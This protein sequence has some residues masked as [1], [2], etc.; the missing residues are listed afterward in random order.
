MPSACFDVMVIGSNSFCGAGFVDCMLTQGY[1]VLGVSRSHLGDPSFCR[2]A[3]NEKI[4]NFQFHQIDLNASGSI[5]YLGDLLKK[6]ASPVVVNFSAQGMVAQSWDSPVDWYLTNV[7]AQVR[8]FELLRNVRH[9]EQYIHFSTPEVYG[10]NLESIDEGRAHNPTTPY[11]ISRSC[12]DRHLIA[13]SE[14]WG[15][16]AVITRASNVYGAYQQLYRIVPRTVLACLGFEKL[17]LDGGGDSL[18]N[19]LHV[20]DCSNALRL[21]IESSAQKN[22]YHISGDRY[23]SISDLVRK[24]VLAMGCDYLECVNEGPERAGKDYAYKLDAASIVDELGWR[25]SVKL[26]DGIREAVEW[27]RAVKSKI[28]PSQLAYSHKR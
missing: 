3:D 2:F 26:D 23:I 1:R 19:F 21:I 20:D 6:S 18:R 11:A 12:S 13:L 4:S 28:D 7:L 22:S 5:E 24:I 27:L 14:H 16:P 8:L 15:F 10:S 17:T 9:L 25:A